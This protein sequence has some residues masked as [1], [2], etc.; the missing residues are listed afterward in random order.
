MKTKRT[1]MNELT[2]ALAKALADSAAFYLKAQGFHWNVEGDDFPMYHDFF[3]KLYGEVYEAVDTI[4][5]LIRTLDVKSPAGI[6]TLGKLTNISDS[7]ASTSNAM[8]AELFRDNQIVLTSLMEAYRLA[9]RFS[10]F[11]ISNFIQDR[12]QAHKKH[13]WMLRSMTRGDE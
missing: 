6:N 8:I 4:A 13:A 3:S 5:E 10:E 7:T 1:K 2:N 9:E 12:I 11:G